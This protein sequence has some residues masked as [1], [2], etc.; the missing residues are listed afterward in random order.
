MS[1][2]SSPNTQ[3]SI[4]Q[5]K[6]LSIAHHDTLLRAIENVFSTD[7]TETTM[8]QLVDGL[9]LV[10]VLREARGHDAYL[11]HPIWSHK[12]LCEGAREKYKALKAEFNAEGILF[13][14]AVSCCSFTSV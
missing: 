6:D 14:Q 7:L 1:T 8:A 5:L 11:E 2:T 13:D 4:K 12:E 3:L 9:I 10:D